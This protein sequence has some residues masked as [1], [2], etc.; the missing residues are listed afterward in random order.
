MKNKIISRA[1]LAL[2]LAGAVA[3]QPTVAATVKGVRN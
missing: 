2:M 3:A 1:M